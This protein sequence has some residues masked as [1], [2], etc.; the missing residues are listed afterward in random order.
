MSLGTRM[1]AA[2]ARGLGVLLSGTASTKRPAAT[3]GGKRGTADPYLEGVKVSPLFPM[4]TDLAETLATEAPYEMLEAYAEGGADIK[5]GDT[6]IPDGLDLELRV[7]VV[8]EWPQQGSVAKQMA[9]EQIK[10]TP[11]P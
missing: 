1:G 9:L 11:A 4:S 8:R 3:S 7:K 6:L 2:L 10:R 5:E